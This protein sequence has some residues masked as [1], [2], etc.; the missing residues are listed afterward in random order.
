MSEWRKV[1]RN[2]ATPKRAAVLVSPA[3]VLIG[4]MP[5]EHADLI[6]AAMTERDALR[7]ERDELR[8]L[9][10]DARTKLPEE[11]SQWARAVQGAKD[12]RAAE[13]DALSKIDRITVGPSPSAVSAWADA[14]RE[15]WAIARAALDNKNPPA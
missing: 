1:T 14:M 5:H 13:R 2:R 3:G 11:T 9:W 6:L 7:T 8:R 15:A 10:N 12:E 4:P